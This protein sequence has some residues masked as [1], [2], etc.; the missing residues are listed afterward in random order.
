MIANVQRR[1]GARVHCIYGE[2]FEEAY[3]K[4]NKDKEDEAV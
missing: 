4:L 1:C 2:D 3:C